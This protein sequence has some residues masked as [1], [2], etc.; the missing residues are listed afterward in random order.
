M[1][2]LPPTSFR[3]YPFRPVL[4]MQMMLYAWDF[5]VAGSDSHGRGKV[6]WQEQRRHLQMAMR[7][8]RLRT[9]A[10]LR[11]QQGGPRAR[12]PHRF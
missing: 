7:P 11:L 10:R 1:T 8:H 9:V 2:D 4:T 12:E 5:W 3:R 6:S